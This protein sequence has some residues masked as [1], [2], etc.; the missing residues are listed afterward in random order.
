MAV[1]YFQFHWK[2]KLDEWHFLPIV[3]RGELAVVFCF[4]FL[5][6]T[7]RGGGIWSIDAVLARRLQD[8][9]RSDATGE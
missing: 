9:T 5:Y 1:A 3:N 2:L 7:T 6:I 4:L 8:A